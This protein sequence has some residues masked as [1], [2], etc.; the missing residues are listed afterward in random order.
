MEI[1]T[2]WLRTITYSTALW[3]YP[4]SRFS[5]VTQ[6]RTA[7]SL[8]NLSVRTVKHPSQFCS[9]GQRLIRAPADRLQYGPAAALCLVGVVSKPLSVDPIGRNRLGGLVMR[10][11][12]HRS[13]LTSEFALLFSFSANAQTWR[14]LGAPGGDVQSFAAAPG[15]TC[16][17]R[18]DS[19]FAGGVAVALLKGSV[20]R[21]LRQ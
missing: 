18:L 13:V 9:F 10:V 2:S 16:L 20:R 11:A 4:P 17:R 3:Q 12:Y 14:Q 5:Q 15:N 6:S 1:L 7:H 8:L 19:S 21:C